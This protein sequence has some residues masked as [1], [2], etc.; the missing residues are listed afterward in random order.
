MPE[1]PTKT[2]PP[3]VVTILTFLTVF[4]LVYLFFSKLTLKFYAS[5]L[6][7]LYHHIQHMW[8]SVIGLGIIQTALFLPFRVINLI[9]QSHVKEFETKVD[10]L[11][12]QDQQ[13]FLI[14][15][16]VKGG[17]PTI[18]WYIINFVT[19]IVAYISIGRLFLIDFYNYKLNPDLLFSFSHY[20]QYPIKDPI[21][22]LPYPYAQQTQ[23]FGLIWVFVAWGS[24]L[25]LKLI[26][27]RFIKYYHHLAPGQKIQNDTAITRT[28]KSFIKN[29]TGFL[30]IFLP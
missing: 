11:K 20:P 29:S 3:R 24:I 10:E 6:F 16:T 1:R 28:L 4:L 18:L 23:D 26:Y 2:S 9:L 25:L 19:Q 7:F 30:T 15:Q 17:D 12:D 21:F 27:N 22:K 8:L 5:I 13:Q 14:K